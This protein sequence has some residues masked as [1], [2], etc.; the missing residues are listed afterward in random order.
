MP[1]HIRVQS[2]SYYK[3]LHHF[4]WL[5]C[6]TPDPAATSTVSSTVAI[7]MR[8][9]DAQHS[10]RVCE[11][12]FTV[13]IPLRS[14]RYNLYA[15]PCTCTSTY[16]RYVHAIST[17]CDQV[18]AKW[19][20]TTS[21]RASAAQGAYHIMSL[22]P[23][24]TQATICVR[25]RDCSPHS[26]TAHGTFKNRQSYFNKCLTAKPCVRMMSEHVRS[27]NGNITFVRSGR[28]ACSRVMV[29]S[30][31][32]NSRCAHASHMYFIC[33][34]FGQTMRMRIRGRVWLSKG[35]GR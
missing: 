33:R 5:T 34:L 35:S 28:R 3:H 22:Q 27:L 31:A 4:R 30:V 32:M 14:N 13:Y 7:C 6:R 26:H 1:A 2:Y 25:P 20:E 19:R 11:F 8:A 16:S 15:V 17:T 24:Q 23:T 21:K 29:E 12:T 9:G 18:H 10:V